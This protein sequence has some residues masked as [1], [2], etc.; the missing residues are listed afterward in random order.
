[1]LYDSHTLSIQDINRYTGPV[2]EEAL[3]HTDL[4]SD[5]PLSKR[6]TQSRDRIAP[7]RLAPLN[8]DWYQRLLMTPLEPAQRSYMAQDYSQLV[9]QR[10]QAFLSSYGITLERVQVYALTNPLNATVREAYG[11]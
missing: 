2:I 9:H 5:R 11:F 8:A 4:R 3:G 6:N 1:M 10:L 7:V